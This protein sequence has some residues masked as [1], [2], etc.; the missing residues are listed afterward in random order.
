MNK[1]TTRTTIVCKLPF[2]HQ[3]AQGWGPLGGGVCPCPFPH[4]MSPRVAEQ[5]ELLWA[6]RR[7]DQLCIKHRVSMVGD[8]AN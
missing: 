3:R 4:A 6:V 1:K 8:K 2:V 5:N 7:I